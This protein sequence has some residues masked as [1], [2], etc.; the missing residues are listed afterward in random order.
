MVAATSADGERCGVVGL[1]VRCTSH[2]ANLPRRERGVLLGPALD[3]A[4]DDPAI[5]LVRLYPD[6]ND[7]RMAVGLLEHP[8][9]TAATLEA[10][11]WMRFE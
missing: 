2:I 8:E 7:C 4:L 9:W 5:Y 10:L 6:I 1:C 3:R 11:G